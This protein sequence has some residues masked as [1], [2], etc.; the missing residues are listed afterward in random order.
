ME[1]NTS[2]EYLFIV[3]C[4]ESVLHDTKSAFFCSILLANYV[5]LY[6]S[7]STVIDN[8]LSDSDTVLLRPITHGFGNF[9]LRDGRTK[10][11]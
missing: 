8:R 10:F 5:A 6:F 3:G 4:S 2:F 7:N 1:E 11:F 9:S